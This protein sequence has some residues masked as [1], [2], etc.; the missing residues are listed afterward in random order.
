[1]DHAPK[2][3]PEW[4]EILA[5]EEDVPFA[6]AHGKTMPIKQTLKD[7]VIASKCIKDSKIDTQETLKEEENKRTSIDGPEDIYPDYT[8]IPSHFRYSS[9]SHNKEV[10]QSQR[11]LCK[12]CA[13]LDLDTLFKR[14]HKT[15][16][17]QTVKKK[18]GPA[19]NLKPRSCA[20]CHLLYSSLGPHYQKESGL[21]PL[22]TFS[23]TRLRDNTWS[24]IDTN[25]IQAHYTCKYIVSQPQGLTGPIRIVKDHIQDYEIFKDW[26]NLCR[27]YHTKVCTVEISNSV[28]FQKLIDCETRII[29][30]ASNHPYVA[31]SYVWGLNSEKS[32]FSETLPPNLPNTIEDTISVTLKLGFRYLWI[33]RYCINQQSEEE[34]EAQIPAMD[35]IYQKA[36]VTIIAAAGSDPSY[37]LPGVGNKKR[38]EHARTTCH[39][40]GRDF[41]ITTESAYPLLSISNSIW[42]TRA[43]TYQEAI[44]SRRRLVFADEEVYFEC[45]GMHCSESHN[46]PLLDM[47]REDMQGFKHTFCQGKEVGMFPKGVGTTDLA[48]LHRIEEYSKLN[49]TYPEDVLRGISGILNSFR[50]LGIRHYAGIPIL[51]RRPRKT[52]LEATEWTLTMGFLFSLL[53]EIKSP[54][55]RRTGSG[56]AEFPSW[57]WAGWYGPVEWKV[58]LSWLPSFKIDPNVQLNVELM[59]G[60]ALKLEECHD[61]AGGGSS[62]SRPSTFIRISAWTVRIY[63]PR[64]GRKENTYVGKIDIEDGGYIEWEFRSMSKVPLYRDEVC[65]G[66][67]LGYISDIPE[68]D[69]PI[70]LILNRLGDKLER[71]GFGDLTFFS[72]FTKD[73]IYRELRQQDQEGYFIYTYLKLPELVKSWKEVRLG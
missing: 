31:L 27:A 1:M 3:T 19:Q 7:K 5:P 30:P 52:Q 41:L 23:S 20:F 49:L 66:I 14:P 53:W 64:P 46:F 55:E 24:S 13:Q 58:A 34:R 48:I 67:I 47:H 12:D 2:P 8:A 45:F 32:S 33:D 42:K 26:I 51:P 11:T 28:L 57:S 22:R 40:V 10:A 38:E 17:G 39:K 54:S 71:I 72:A 29:I 70:L 62:Q 15:V 73:G 25:L 35:I 68:R 6:K 9:G 61:L 60:R 56:V 37:G 18:L 65:T 4:R 50:R 63:H 16:A 21:I 44:L 69:T 36:E 43:W 59:D